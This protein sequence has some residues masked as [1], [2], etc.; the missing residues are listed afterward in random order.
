MNG[1]K[2]EDKR[3]VERRERHKATMKE[4]RPYGSPRSRMGTI[5]RDGYRNRWI[6]DHKGFLNYAKEGGYSFVSKAN[7]EFAEK[8]ARNIDAGLG[9]YVSMITDRDG[10]RSYLMEIPEELYEM[11]QKAK[12]NKIDDGESAIRQGKGNGGSF[13]GEG[14]YIPSEGI[15]IENNTA[16]Y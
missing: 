16:K 5:E 15:S 2:S 8:D 1:K 9:E 4:R 6:K 10:S 7:G 14:R 3:S 12:S 13:G 11:D